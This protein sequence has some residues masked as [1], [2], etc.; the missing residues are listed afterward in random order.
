MTIVAL[1]GMGGDFAP[2]ATVEAAIRAQK[3]DGIEVIL[4]EKS[5]TV[6]GV[7]ICDME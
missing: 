3:E 6:G 2:R 5:S 7:C 1:D 4:V